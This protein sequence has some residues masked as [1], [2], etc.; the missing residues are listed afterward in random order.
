MSYF[1]K[2]VNFIFSQLK[3]GKFSSLRRSFLKRLYYKETSLGFKLDLNR[4]LTKPRS[5]KKIEIRKSIKGD[6]AFFISDDSNNGLIDQIKTC[7]VAT[8][9]DGIPCFRCWMI[10]FTQN[11]KLEE[12]WGSTFPTLQKDEVLLES[13]Y[14]IPQYRG[15]GLHPAVMHQVAMKSKEFG[16]NFAISFSYIS[17]INS[18]RSFNYAGFYPY[19]LRKEKYFLFR[20]SVSFEEIPPEILEYYNKIIPKKVHTVK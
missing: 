3:K 1:L 11:K 15:L 8:I 12:I 10:D 9:N 5:L 14:T 4:E 17:N 7:Y 20:K 13:A 18:L 19:I 2:R 6:E 16:A